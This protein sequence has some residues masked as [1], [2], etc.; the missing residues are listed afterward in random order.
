MKKKSKDLIFARVA[1]NFFDWVT[2]SSYDT[3]ISNFFKG[4]IIFACFIA[5][6]HISLFV[7]SL[8]ALILWL[9]LFKGTE[10][11]FKLFPKSITSNDFL[12]MEAGLISFLLT[13]YG[14]FLLFGLGILIWDMIKKN[15]FNFNFFK[16]SKDFFKSIYYLGYSFVVLNIIFLSLTVMGLLIF[17]LI[18]GFLL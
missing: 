1:S 15:K 3:P 14:I 12:S 2:K 11:F 5:I 8:P 7:V 6:V 4:L 17:G 10:T 9:T 13:A 16:F 18:R